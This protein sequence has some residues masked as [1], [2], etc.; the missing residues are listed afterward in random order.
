MIDHF[1][2][3]L[4]HFY[5]DLKSMENWNYRL[6]ILSAWKISGNYDKIQFPMYFCFYLQVKGV[7][8]SLPYF[9]GLRVPKGQMLHGAMQDTSDLLMNKDGSTKLYQA[10]VYLSPGDYHRFHSPVE[11]TIHTRRYY[12]FLK[13]F[14]GVSQQLRGHNF[15]I[16]WPL[17]PFSVDKKRHFFGPLPPHV[18][19]QWPLYEYGCVIAWLRFF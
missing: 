6:Q 12:F 19:I 15:S 4:P 16:F 9:L 2:N 13:I 14:L 1:S 18:V 3:D 11:W 7:H 17:N 5:N 8:Y 10:V